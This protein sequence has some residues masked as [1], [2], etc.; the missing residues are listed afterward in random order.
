MFETADLV[1][2]RSLVFLVLCSLADLGVLWELIVFRGHGGQSAFSTRALRI[3]MQRHYS[4]A[5]RSSMA[6]L[7]VASEADAFA[8]AVQ[9][10]QGIRSIELCRRMSLTASIV[11][12]K[13]S[14]RPHAA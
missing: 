14:A 4:P 6:D 7:Q 10:L 13:G 8:A 1:V 3:R 2:K 9:P 5:D 11:P 12:G